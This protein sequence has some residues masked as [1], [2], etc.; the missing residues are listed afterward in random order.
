MPAPLKNHW[1]EGKEGNGDLRT[2]SGCTKTGF[3]KRTQPE[4]TSSLWGEG[5]SGRKQ[6]IG[7]R[8]KTN[9][10]PISMVWLLR[11]WPLGVGRRPGYVTPSVR[12]GRKKK[13]N[14]TDSWRRGRWYRGVKFK[15][16]GR[17]LVLWQ[18]QK[19]DANEGVRRDAAGG[20]QD[21]GRVVEK[22]RK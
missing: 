15:A 14:L 4:L 6:I 2:P 16:E 17:Y 21:K 3:G 18:G 9:R 5:I 22:K 1:T 19:E 13:R 20:N 8:R 10:C 11:G 12:W 7:L